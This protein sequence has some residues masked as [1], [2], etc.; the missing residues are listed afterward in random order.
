MD[1]CCWSPAFLLLPGPARPMHLAVLDLFL[2]I[3][4]EAAYSNAILTLKAI[5]SIYR[6]QDTGYISMPELPQLLQGLSVP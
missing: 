1:I 6:V 3:L 5:V 2:G 4:F